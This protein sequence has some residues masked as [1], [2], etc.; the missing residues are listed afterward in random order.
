MKEV[1]DFTDQVAVVTGAASGIGE[2]IA[3]E[4]ASES[5]GIAVI[6]I[7]VERGTTVADRIAAEHQVETTMVETDVS[8][9]ESC[10][11]AIE[12]VVDELGGIDIL[13][14]CVAGETGDLSAMTKPFVEERP[15]DWEPQ[16]QVTLT[17]T[18]NMTHAV[19]PEM[20]DR[21][22]GS[23]I[24]LIS[25]S[26]QGHDPDLTVYAAAKA[27]LVTFTK[28]L[29]KEVGEHGIR[30]NAISPGTTETPATEAWIEQYGDK[31]VQAYP[32]GRLGQPEDHAYAAAFLASDAADWITGQTLSVNGGFL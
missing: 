15:E 3:T 12:T 23:V 20:I 32:L 7:A 30:V 1:I 22:G 14:N 19:L 31:V 8:D 13:V 24:S 11:S 25:D 4:L 26:Y 27:A 17:G 9:Y 29:S 28:S 10:R 2:A 18:L 21:G 6:D 5:A 16:I